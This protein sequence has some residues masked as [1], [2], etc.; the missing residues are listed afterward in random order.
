MIADGDPTIDEE[1]LAELD[2]TAANR[3]ADEPGI[4]R[5]GES[6]NLGNFL[7][8]PGLGTLGARNE[9]REARAETLLKAMIV[10]DE[11]TLKRYH[12]VCVA[13]AD[14]DED[15]ERGAGCSICWE[16]LRMAEDLKPIAL[17]CTHVFHDGCLKSWFSESLIPS[18][19]A[20]SDVLSV[21][22]RFD[23]SRMSIRSRSRTSTHRRP[24]IFAI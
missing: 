13:N 7:L 6:T 2:P 16:T 8:S 14:N 23:M 24:Y 15:R 9:T 10:L 4:Q 18:V 17:P 12:R 11:D 20:E 22:T 5:P 3:L 19:L 21:S 1:P